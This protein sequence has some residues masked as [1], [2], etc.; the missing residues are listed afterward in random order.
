M[1]VGHTG[2]AAH[3]VLLSVSVCAR[4]GRDVHVACRERLIYVR[5][6]GVIYSPLITG[7]P[8]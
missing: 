8:G 4:E 5:G 2:G 1:A 7:I 6:S 3:L